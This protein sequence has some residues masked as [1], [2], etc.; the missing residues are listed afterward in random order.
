MPYFLS[1]KVLFG[2]GMLKRLASEIE[3][4]GTKAAIMT[5][6]TMVNHCGQLNEAVQAAGYEV[7]VWDGA[8]QEP[9][10]A[11]AQAGATFLSDFAPQIILGF[12]GGSVIDAAKAAWILYE[13]PEMT[14]ADLVSVNPKTKL[15]LRKKAIFIAVP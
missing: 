4:K 7:K 9:S 13:K 5:D 10:T 12:G 14:G 8:E 11:S 3:G 2:S 6:K 1:P 15:N